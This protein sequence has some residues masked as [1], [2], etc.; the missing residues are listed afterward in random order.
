MRALSLVSGL[1][2]RVR[3]QLT[4][5]RV[6][7]SSSSVVLGSTSSSSSS[8]SS[9]SPSAPAPATRAL[10][11][12]R[13]RGV[14]GLPVGATRFS[15][16]VGSVSAQQLTSVRLMAKASAANGYVDEHSA[17]SGPIKGN[18]GGDAR[19]RTYAYVVMGSSAFLYAAAI[20][21]TVADLVDS[22]NAAAD[23]LALASMEVDLDKVPQGT[24][25]VV[26]W[27]G[28]PVFVRHRTD[29]DISAARSVAVQSL[30]DPQTDE[31]RVQAGKDEWL[32]LVGVCTHLG[33]VPISGAGDYN[34]WFCPCHGSH[35]DTS[36]R[37]RKGP[38]PLNLA[39][40]PYKFI[41][42]DSKL[43]IG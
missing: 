37:I 21:S 10:V 7:P 27:R 9:S 22:M 18:V 34:G 2:V 28:K 24:T 4:A 42:N 20:R 15:A 11:A 5:S 6:L 3:A 38:A 16:T 33:C 32:V 17:H 29:D 25:L 1:P 36:G 14:F 31:A 13:A 40:P 8:S 30:P 12:Q 23:V 35:Y 41:E 19:K 26:K 43:L 39:V